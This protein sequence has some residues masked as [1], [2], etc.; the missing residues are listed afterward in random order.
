MQMCNNEEI[1]LISYWVHCSHHSVSQ[2]H[3]E[4]TK[5]IDLIVIYQLKKKKE[6]E[7]SVIL[8]WESNKHNYYITE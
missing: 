1:F 7:E 6:K 2:I 3:Q 8:S 4:Q 5:T